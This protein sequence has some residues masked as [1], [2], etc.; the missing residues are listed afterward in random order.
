LV[1][2]S[3]ATQVLQPALALSTHMAG[4]IYGVTVPAVL[5]ATPE[6][7]YVMC[8]FVCVC[9]SVCVC[10]FVHSV[11]CTACHTWL[12]IYVMCAFVCVYVLCVCVCVCARCLLYCLPHLCV[13]E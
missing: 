4:W 13:H 7:A 1:V 3:K 5:L 6:C 11:C 8:A 12:C 9:V 2:L 10:V